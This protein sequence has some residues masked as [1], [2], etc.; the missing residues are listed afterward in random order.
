M[1]ETVSGVRDRAVVGQLLGSET[2]T[3]LFVDGT[4][5]KNDA[6]NISFA[7][8]GLGH[9]S[10]SPRPAISEL[11]FRNAAS[12]WHYNGVGNPDTATV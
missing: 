4:S 1:S 12:K 7:I 9:I 2:S 6:E 8:L 11:T 10:I 3:C 5:G